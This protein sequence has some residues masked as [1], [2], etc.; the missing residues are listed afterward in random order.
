VAEEV[1]AL[2]TLGGG[3]HRDEGDAAAHCAV[4]EQRLLHYRQGGDL[5][6]DGLR[7]AA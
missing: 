3:G 5:L 1:Y 7:A 2:E 4:K 6:W